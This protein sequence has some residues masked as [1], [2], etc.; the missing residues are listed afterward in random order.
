MSKKILIVHGWLH[1]ADM[2]KKLKADLEKNGSYQVKLY[3]FPGFGNTPVEKNHRL[4]DYY[5]RKIEKELVEGCYDCV[6][7]HSMGGTILLR[8]LAGKRSGAKLILLSP[9]YGGI[10]L[11]KPF[12]IF[13]PVMPLALSLLKKGSC[14]IT[15]F[16]IKCMALFTINRWEKI[17][18]QIVIDAKRADPLVAACTMTEL[19]WDNWRVKRGDRKYGK[20]QLILGERDRIITQRK[21]KCL[22]NDIGKC[23]IHVIKGIGH[24]A[25]LEAYDKL[26][27][28]LLKIVR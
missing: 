3:E 14:F 27:E 11:L 25:V 6:I 28:I 19:V 18:D 26:L 10:A 17:D 23:H 13:M 2:Y 24:T 4:L 21:M 12:V 9:E 7:G 8:A 20:V 16:F 22:C 1:S 5:T 15:T